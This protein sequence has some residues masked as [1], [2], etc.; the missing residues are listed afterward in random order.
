M[1]Y[2]TCGINVTIYFM[3]NKISIYTN[4]GKAMANRQLNLLVTAMITLT[5]SFAH[6]EAEKDS[7]INE[8]AQATSAG[9][10][11]ESQL[12]LLFRNFYMNRDF[13]NS[14]HN[15][16]GAN[17]DAQSYRE[18]WAQGFI[19]NYSSG[20][21]QGTVGFGV[22]AIGM[23]GFKLDTGKGRN[24]NGLLPINKQGKAE[25]N[26]SKAVGSVKA[27]VSNTVL[28]Y[29]EQM[30]DT[31]V[32][33]T[34]D[35]RLLPETAEGF[36]LTS[37]EIKDLTLTAG[38]FTSLRALNQSG[39]DSIDNGWNLYNHKGIGLKRADFIGATYQ[40]TDNLSASLYYSNVKDFWKKKYLGIDYAYPIDDKQA[41]NVSFNYYN[42]KS[43]GDVKRLSKDVFNGHRIDSD[44]WSL[45]SSYTY[46]AHKFTA[47]YQQVTGKGPGNPYGVEG[48][49]A[50]YLANSVQYSDFNS[51]GERSWQL[52]YDLDMG[53]YGVP[54]LSLMTRYV[55]G[56]NISEYMRS[57][58]RT[59]GKVSER[60][61]DFEAKYVVQ[62]GPAKD[63]SI[64]VRYAIYRSSGFAEDINDL[65]IIT[66]YPWDILGT[67]KK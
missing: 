43:Q 27:R 60:E 65:R 44:A 66:E 31:P 19:L 42:T 39:R 4:G 64:R 48:G 1:I 28:K 47:A 36:L 16:Y 15:Q 9:F 51:P 13:R 30:V 7:I 21:T 14:S 18:E 12:N 6:A 58:N 2:F 57:T 38:H 56:S 45:Q 52:R 32:F 5:A 23:Y 10:L 49:G 55:R 24:G 50:I 59:G 8:N 63:L 35:G 33:S 20:F 29:G 61:Q 26:Y 3:K 54:G 67:F 25:D 40:F 34:D 17:K 46:D 53:A 22:D 11:E 41:V 37:N 62:N